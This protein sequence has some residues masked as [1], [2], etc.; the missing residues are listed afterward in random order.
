MKEFLKPHANLLL[1]NWMQLIFHDKYP[2][3]QNP[4]RYTSANIN[5]TITSNFSI[6]M[7]TSMFNNIKQNTNVRIFTEHDNHC[8]MT[9]PHVSNTHTHTHTHTQ[10][11]VV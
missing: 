2:T 9:L 7:L 1:Q 4:S 3:D 11:A 6:E 8:T 10:S 5:V